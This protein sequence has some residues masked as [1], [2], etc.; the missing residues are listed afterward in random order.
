M[1]QTID[2]VADLGE[3]FGKYTIG[4][5]EALLG[6][7]SSA[8]IA[9]GFHAGDPVIM[10]RV[11]GICVDRGVAIGAHPGFDD[12]RGFGRVRIDMPQQQLYAD[13]LYQIGALSA[14]AG[15]H[16]APLH[17]VTPHGKL[18]NLTVEE[19][20]FAK[21]VLDAIRDYST[22]LIIYTQEGVLAELARAEGMRVAIL[23]LADR[24]YQSNGLLVSRTEPTARIKDP[25]D[26]V[27][28]AARML[29]E[30]KVTSID[31]TDVDVPADTILLHGDK[32]EAVATVL[33]LRRA[34]DDA[35]YE[36]AT[37]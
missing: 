3:G 14:F 25:A 2:M 19:E 8:N 11:V 30:G 32:P 13:T 34:C 37:L 9:C 16:R 23:G 29:N 35:G 7:L 26:I 6:A 27:K 33:A 1:A 21:P 4:D 12:R 17:H 36:I 22:D 31:G 20:Y 15:K 10:D 18:G 24:N 28:R 5:D